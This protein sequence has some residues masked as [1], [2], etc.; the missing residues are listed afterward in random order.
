MGTPHRGCYPCDYMGKLESARN[1][2]PQ[3]LLVLLTA[4]AIHCVGGACVAVA[5]SRVYGFPWHTPLSL[6]L[7]TISGPLAI[8]LNPVELWGRPNIPAT[9]LTSLGCIVFMGA[10]FVR[11]RWHT[12]ILLV[13]GYVLWLGFGL[14][15]TYGGK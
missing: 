6:W 10:Y 9:L 5:A 8:F 12:A 11:R 14:A 7:S 1:E 15:I 2:S 3:R 4:V 13:L